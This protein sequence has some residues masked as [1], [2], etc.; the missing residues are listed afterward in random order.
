MAAVSNPVL[1]QRDFSSMSFARLSS[2]LSAATSSAVDLRKGRILAY[3]F[4]IRGCA[5]ENYGN[6]LLNGNEFKGDRV[7]GNE[8]LK[9][10]AY[11]PSLPQL[12]RVSEEV[13]RAEDQRPGVDPRAGNGGAAANRGNFAGA[14]GQPSPERI[15][16]A[17]DVDEGIDLTFCDDYLAF[18]F[19]SVLSLKFAVDSGGKYLISFILPPSNEV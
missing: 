13:V 7:G 19:F 6:V 4:R 1:G 14:V 8:A 2:N 9:A 5:S 18:F 17:V 10:R 11:G 12:L 3:G 16:V 15:M